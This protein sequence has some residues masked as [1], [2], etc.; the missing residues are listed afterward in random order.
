M[1]WTVPPIWEGDDVW[2]LGG[3]PSV[4]KQFGIPDDVV[5]KVRSGELPPSVYSPYMKDIHDCHVIGINVAYLIG[6]WIDMVFFGDAKFY[7]RYCQS[8]AKWHGLKVSCTPTI[9]K[10]PWI[11]Y[12]GKDE[13]H[14][15]GISQ[16]KDCI[17]WNHNSGASAVS[18][19]A[20]LGAKRI[21]LLGFDMRNDETGKRHWHNL[22]KAPPA[23]VPAKG[24][25][26]KRHKG[27]VITK[28]PPFSKHLR[29]FPEMAR[30][31]KAMG[32]EIINACPESA[33]TVFPKFSLKE[34]LFDNS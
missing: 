30:N 15:Y 14:P 3:G 12:L 13:A 7:L 17:S 28:I 33:I 9:E 21:I 5:S 18:L 1:K 26:P 25:L 8:L 27:R 22:Y 20:H 24:V 2:I 32:I 23:S 6:D 31:A 10:I 19:A 11:K 29:G 34:L 4:T 16:R